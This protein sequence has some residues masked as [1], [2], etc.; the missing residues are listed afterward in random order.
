MASTVKRKQPAESPKACT[1]Y[2]I[3]EYGS[4]EKRDS[5]SDKGR[6]LDRIKRI[7]KE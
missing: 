5:D 1:V 6:F 4:F 3:E 2:Q 7:K